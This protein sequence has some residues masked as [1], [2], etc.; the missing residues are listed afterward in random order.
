MGALRDLNSTGVIH[1]D[2]KLDNVMVDL[3]ND[4]CQVKIIDFGL[5]LKT[6]GKPYR[7]TNSKKILDFVQLDPILAN[8]GMCSDKTD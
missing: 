2:L 5:A 4:R 8:G 6:G 1:N 3:K 7:H